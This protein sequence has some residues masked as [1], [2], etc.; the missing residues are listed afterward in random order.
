MQTWRRAYPSL[1]AY[2]QAVAYLPYGQIGHSPPGTFVL[3]FT[4]G[5]IGKHSLALPF[6]WS[7]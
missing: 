6:V 1:N 7:L 4:I 2:L 3:F 5:K